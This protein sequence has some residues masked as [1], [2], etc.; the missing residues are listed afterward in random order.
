[1][2]GSVLKIFAFDISPE[3]FLFSRAVQV[4]TKFSLVNW[5]LPLALPSFRNWNPAIAAVPKK[6]WQPAMKGFA[7]KWP[8]IRVA[9]RLFASTWASIV[10][11]WH[12][13]GFGSHDSASTLSSRRKWWVASLPFVYWMW[14]PSQK[15]AS[16]KAQVNTLVW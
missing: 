5:I 11:Q 13:S 6:H 7:A 12:P 16:S 4:L 3:R 1:M 8:S 2:L 10:M 14:F 9:S 15:S